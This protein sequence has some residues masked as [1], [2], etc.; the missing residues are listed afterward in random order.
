MHIG[1]LNI[2]ENTGFYFQDG[3]TDY[4]KWAEGAERYLLKVNYMLTQHNHKYVRT[5]YSIFDFLA[6]IGGLIGALGPINSV[7]IMLLQFRS[8]Y[9]T[10]LSYNLQS[11]ER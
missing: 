8:S 3:E 7:M 5:V 10:I 1:D 11:S 6:D 9:F 4:G 2:E